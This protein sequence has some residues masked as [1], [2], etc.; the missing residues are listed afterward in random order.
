M[1]SSHK[2]CAKVNNIIKDISLFTTKG[3]M[4]GQMICIMTDCY[5]VRD[6]FG[7][8]LVESIDSISL[9]FLALITTILLFHN[10][11]VFAS[12]RPKA[13]KVRGEGF[14]L[15][16]LLSNSTKFIEIK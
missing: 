8:M 10:T 14:H 4:Q 9:I 13:E 15:T 1:I 7:N 3:I 5:L 6:L 16:L 11:L 2:S 12:F